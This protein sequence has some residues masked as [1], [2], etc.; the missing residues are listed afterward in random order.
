MSI[1]VYSVNML[2]QTALLTG[3]A[4]LLG[5]RLNLLGLL[6]PSVHS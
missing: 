6:T 3:V 2:V 4:A 5:F 1:A